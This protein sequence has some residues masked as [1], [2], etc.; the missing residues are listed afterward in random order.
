MLYPGDP[1]YF[2]QLSTDERKDFELNVT[3]DEMIFFKSSALTFV[4]IEKKKT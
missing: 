4:T 1:L 2:L 3:G